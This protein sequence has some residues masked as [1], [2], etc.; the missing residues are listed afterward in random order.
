M[1]A[2]LAAA[3]WLLAAPSWGQPEVRLPAVAGRSHGA[4][5]LRF[6]VVR[7][8]PPPERRSGPGERAQAFAACLAPRSGLHQGSLLSV[9]PEWVR[10]GRRGGAVYV[11]S[12]YMA[13][14]HC[15]ANPNEDRMRRALE[16]RGVRDVPEAELPAVYQR[17][18]IDP[19]NDA[20]RLCG[21]C[22][23][24]VQSL[25]RCAGYSGTGLGTMKEQG[26]RAEAY[27]AGSDRS[28]AD[29]ASRLPG[30]LRFGDVF[31]Y[32]HGDSGHMFLYTG[33]AGLDYEVVEMGGGAS[34]ECRRVP[35][36]AGE[37]NC[38]RAHASRDGYHGWNRS[39]DRCNVFRV[40]R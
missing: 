20:G 19:I 16:R 9:L 36:L 23:T 27:V 5:E 13:G 6:P 25:F 26:T 1:K 39:V 12:G 38:V 32:R 29:A 37:I 21:D 3:A 31:Q 10:I 35:G 30:G 34:R 28:C 33:G 11:L 22:V 40:L 2:L 4:P 17:T 24:W 8:A 15:Q 7:A 14:R 18:I